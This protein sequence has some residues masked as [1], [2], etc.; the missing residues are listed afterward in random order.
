MTLLVNRIA[1]DSESGPPILQYGF[2]VESNNSNWIHL[3]APDGLAASYTLTLPSNNGTL[4]S[5]ASTGSVSQTMLAA[6][7]AGNGPIFEAHASADQAVSVNTWTLVVLNTVVADSSSRFNNTAAT[8][9]GIPAYSFMPNV[10]GWYLV[11][12][13]IRAA[14][15]LSLLELYKNGTVYTRITEYGA[16]GGTSHTGTCIV[17]LNGTTDYIS[18]YAYTN[19]SPLQTAGNG[20]LY[21]CRMSAVLIRR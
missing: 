8:V 4:I 1:N 19:T 2:K 6:G 17:Y 11:S 21:G 20:A 12:A 7:V 15:T 13:R 9:N 14:G 16:G 3:K 18:L 5:T 10:A